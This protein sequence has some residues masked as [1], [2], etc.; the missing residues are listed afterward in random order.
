MLIMWFK[1]IEG[2]LIINFSLEKAEE[3]WLFLVVGLVIGE[4]DTWINKI[5][6]SGIKAFGLRL[7]VLVWWLLICTYIGVVRAN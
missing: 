6:W 3:N 2:S 4:L 1:L 7:C 5:I